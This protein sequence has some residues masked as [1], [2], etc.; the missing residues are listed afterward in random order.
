MVK[1]GPEAIFEEL[2]AG[3]FPK[4]MKEIKPHI[5]E[6]LQ[7]QNKINTMKTTSE[8][9]II[10]LIKKKQSKAKCLGTVS[11]KAWTNKL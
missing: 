9:I 11:K 7:T 6:A 1:N 4:L 2:M 10:S 5:P 3:N 8:Y